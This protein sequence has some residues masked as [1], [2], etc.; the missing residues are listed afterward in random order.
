MKIE[1][2]LMDDWLTDNGRQPITNICI[3]YVDVTE[4]EIRFALT[5]LNI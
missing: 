1:D 2:I 4:N 5:T 3:E